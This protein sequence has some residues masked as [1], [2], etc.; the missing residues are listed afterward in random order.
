[1]SKNDL[2]SLLERLG[3]KIVLTDVS[4]LPALGEILNDLDK[5]EKLSSDLKNKQIN[6]HVEWLKATI[7][8][9]IVGET[10]SPAEVFNE[11]SKRFSDLQTLINSIV[12]DS[13]RGKDKRKEV[14]EY[15]EVVDKSIFEEFIASLEVNLQEIEN[16]ILDY[17]NTGKQEDLN[18]LKRIIHTIK[19]ESGL[20][21]VD[22]LN[23]V[24][25]ALE[26]FLSDNED[27]DVDILYRVKDWCEEVVEYYSGQRDAYTH[28]KEIIGLLEP[29]DK[30]ERKVKKKKE[31]KKEERKK[32]EIVK[33][34]KPK[35]ILIEEPEEEPE[36][37]FEVVEPYSVDVE[38]LPDFINEANEHIEN[39][40][41]NLL[42]IENDPSNVEALNAVFRSFHTIKGVAGFIG[43]K[44][45]QELSHRAENLLDKA[46]NGK[47]VLEGENIDLVFRAVD[48][49]KEMIKDL[50]EVT[51]TGV[52]KPQGREFYQLIKDIENLI[53]LV[54]EGIIEVEERVEEKKPVLGQKKV[55]EEQPEDGDEETATVVEEPAQDE[56]S[57]DDQHIA[58]DVSPEVEKADV[59]VQKVKL[60]EI[61]KIDADRLDRL[62]DTIGEL[63]IAESMVTQ[64]PEV[65]SI[66]SPRLA[67]Y[68]SQLDKITRELQELGTSLRMIPIKS[69][70]QKMARLVRDLSKKAGKKIE[71][72]TYGE[73][74]E[75]DKSVV[76]K[77]GD[78]LV[79]MIRNSIDHGIEDNPEER[80]KRGKPE[81]GKIELRA[82]HRGGNI[83]I[84][85]SDD[86][87]GLDRDKILRKAIERGL[88]K[89]GKELS[90]N[91]VWNLIFS[92]GFSTADVVT[93][94]SGRGVGLDVV[95]RNIESIRGRIDVYTK[96]GE[97]TTFRLILPLTLAIIDGMVI[98]VGSER[99]I[100]P[101]LSVVT[102]FRPR[103]NDIS[104][105]MK[106]GEIISFHGELLPLIR[107]YK[108]FDIENAKEDP[109]NALVV[110]VESEN[111]KVGI[112]ADDLIG[113][114]QVVIKPLGTLLKKVP[115][116]SGGAIMPDGRV[117][118]I[119]DVAGL[120][121]LS[122]ESNVI[123]KVIGR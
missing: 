21:G 42:T 104:T 70:F 46:R 34:E 60:K 28:V 85:V 59:E 121:R 19:G 81:Y 114:Q 80:I 22:D 118:L 113:Q 2:V 8:K 119:I 88:V 43:L 78:P 105:L 17:E 120:I 37:E 20:V 55:K 101:T 86:G 65:K 30:K 47:V 50:E 29:G 91:E 53:R 39:A 116:I 64:A 26:D 98:K 99:Y 49:L 69:T 7:E 38:L 108:L 90:D 79:H 109:Y 61:I 97:G 76:D 63:V 68:V 112:L 16:L 93:D 25:H 111:I 24:C 40:D 73:D 94:V 77:I 67:K 27:I 72:V 15:N 58:L 115:G 31:K 66:E 122:R 74:T 95:K 54:D 4:D 33:E 36:E 56:K 82:Y 13:E 23:K 89:E 32:E 5:I 107:L 117:G 35:P 11:V 44:E 84:E 92:P 100:I 41:L 57:K 62:V 102:T 106:K 52:V 14:F 48:K 12:R 45:I 9:I 75:L 71:F 51:K 123:E 103:N 6:D 83:I 3:E 96:S 87:K 10:D 110:V 18:Q 1:M